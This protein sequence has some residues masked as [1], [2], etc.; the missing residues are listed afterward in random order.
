MIVVVYRR[1][2][3]FR[4][5]QSRARPTEN[6]NRK[7]ARKLD[8][9]LIVIQINIQ[10]Y[11]FIIEGVWWNGRCRIARS[12]ERADDDDGDRSPACSTQKTIILRSFYVYYITRRP[13]EFDFYAHVWRLPSING[14]Q[15]ARTMRPQKDT[16]IVV[17][18]VRP[19]NRT[20]TVI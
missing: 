12:R 18:K 19:E 4:S 1:T 8:G 5:Q 17:F 6:N 11:A 16:G 10:P 9:I 3:I 7:N 2:F 13:V 20:V 14:T 15:K